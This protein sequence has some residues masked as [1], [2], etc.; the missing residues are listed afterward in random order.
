ME[1]FEVLNKEYTLK[2]D[3]LGRD[4]ANSFNDMTIDSSFSIIYSDVVNLFRLDEKKKIEKEIIFN[5]Q[6]LDL[7]K[8]KSSYDADKRELELINVS[9]KEQIENGESKKDFEFYMP[10]VITIILGVFLW[11]FYTSTGYAAL[12]NIVGNGSFKVIVNSL[13]KL[14][15]ENIWIKLFFYLFPILFI[16]LGFLI[17]NAI[18]SKKKVNV[19]ILLILTFLFDCIIGY[20]ISRNLYIYNTGNIPVWNPTD[21]FIDENFYLILFCG[22]IAYI[23]W[24]IVLNKYLTDKNNAKPFNQKIRLQ[25]EISENEKKIIDLEGKINECNLKIK[26]IKIDI[27]DLKNNVVKFPSAILLRY[28]GAF[29]NGLNE[30]LKALNPNNFEDKVKIIEL[31]KYE[32]ITKK[33]IKD[34][35]NI[36]I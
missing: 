11:L 4:S 22:F 30:V 20:K 1:D 25:R 5:K 7:E 33:G 9:K 16:T 23:L 12:N 15:T 14:N 13:R 28:F 36:K 21:I 10:L 29:I 32:W 34:G 6:I 31:K 17:H 24:G 8:E 35:E 19:I 26:N 2:Y 27:N 3:Q 18:T